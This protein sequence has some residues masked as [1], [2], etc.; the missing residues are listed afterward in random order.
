M[1][2]RGRRWIGRRPDRQ[3]LRSGY[4]QQPRAGVRFSLRVGRGP[5]PG[6]SGV[7]PEREIHRERMLGRRARVVRTISSCDRSVR[8]PL[9]LRL[10][11]QS[12]AGI[13]HSAQ[14]DRRWLA[15]HR[16][17]SGFRPVGLQWQPMQFLS[18]GECAA[19]RG[20]FMFAQA[21]ALDS[22]ENLYVA[23]F[24]NNRVLEYNTPLAAGSGELAADTV[25]GQGGDFSA[26]ACAG[27]GPNLSPLNADGLCGPSGV[28][29]RFGRQPLY[30]RFAQQ[31]RPPIRHAARK[32]I[33]AQHD[34]KH[35]FRPGRQF[36]DRH[37]HRRRHLVG[38]PGLLPRP[39]GCVRRKVLLSTRAEISG[40]RTT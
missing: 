2:F 14:E 7:R 23:D 6:A 18:V 4:L 26:S 28:A 8:Q 25:F 32:P 29:L 37:L 1:Q 12:R 38:D 9:R 15:R 13:Q 40:S 17:R 33:C 10:R 5:T 19:Q 22:A 16:G 31:P 36:H 39:M 21:L 35:G 27:L 24:G 20:H 34:C 11:Q 30:L 3:P